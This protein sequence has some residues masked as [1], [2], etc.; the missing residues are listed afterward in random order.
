M[1]NIWFLTITV[2]LTNIVFLYGR[3]WNISAIAEKD[4]KGVLISATVVHLSWLISV[5]IGAYSMQKILMN[6]NWGDVPVVLGSLGGGLYGSYIALKNKISKDKRKETLAQTEQKA[7]TSASKATEELPEE[8]TDEVRKVAFNYA[9]NKF[10]WPKNYEKFVE[11]IQEMYYNPD[12]WLNVQS[13]GT[14]NLPYSTKGA[15]LREL[16]LMVDQ[17][18]KQFNLPRGSETGNLNYDLMK[19]ELQEYRDAVKLGDPVKKLDAVADMLYI[20]L[21]II[22]KENMQD[23]IEIAFGEVHASNLS[24]ADRDGKPI[25]RHDGKLLK[26]PDF[27][28]PRLAE[29][30]ALTQ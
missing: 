15:T 3:T 18:H 20:L 14:G 23:V 16:I 4:I 26:G 6:F 9:K 27:K 7:A 5:A 11:R 24:K 17:F 21:G 8:V 13:P 10:F 12:N 19:E 22:L 2:L 29:I 30:Y 25:Y 1:E 28:E